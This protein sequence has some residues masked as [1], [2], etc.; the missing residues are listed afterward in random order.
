MDSNLWKP[1]ISDLVRVIS[2]C[3]L[4][5]PTLALS[6][7]CHRAWCTRYRLS[8]FLWSEEMVTTN[9]IMLM[10]RPLMNVEVSEINCVVSVP[11]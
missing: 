3:Q 7:V 10:R 6:D 8:P 1:L 9:N 4:K 5:T 11:L 2:A